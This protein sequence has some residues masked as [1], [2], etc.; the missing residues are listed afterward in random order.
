M[1][2]CQGQRGPESRN[3]RAWVCVTQGAAPRWASSPNGLQGVRGCG[4]C[5]DEG[6]VA[7]QEEEDEV[8]EHGEDDT[9][10]KT[11]DDGE[12]ERDIATANGNVARQAPQ[13]GNAPDKEESQPE[14]HKSAARH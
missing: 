8:D 7:A 11:G 10:Q 14:Q 9:E 6:S 3:V 2:T 5:P 1:S 4:E 13:Q 12:I